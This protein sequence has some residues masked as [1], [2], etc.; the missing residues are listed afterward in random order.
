M[1]L[2]NDLLTIIS[3]YHEGYRLMRRRMHGHSYGRN[4]SG[5]F[6]SASEPTL[7]VTL[8]RLKKRGLVQNKRGIWFI[9]EKGLEYLSKKSLL[10]LPFSKSN[11]GKPKNMIVAF[12]I[13]ENFKKERNWLRAALKNLSFKMLQKSVWFGPAPLPSDLIFALKEIKILNFIKFFKA[14]ESDI[15]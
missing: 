11:Q 6:A 13:P 7:R 8:S 12:D 14:E 1:P 10:K 2:T 5:H 3:G 9:T 15:V 4:I